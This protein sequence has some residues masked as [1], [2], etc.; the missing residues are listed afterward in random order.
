MGIA[1]IQTRVRR[2]FSIFP[3]TTP[4][5]NA[6]LAFGSLLKKVYVD[7]L[8]SGEAKPKKPSEA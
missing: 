7:L 2:N 8:P 1:N 6:A 4:S 5:R 3:L